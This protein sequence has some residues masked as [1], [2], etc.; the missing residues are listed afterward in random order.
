MG[1]PYFLNGVH[2]FLKYKDWGVQ[3]F[4]NIRTG[5]NKNGGVQIC[6]DSVRIW[7]ESLISWWGPYNH[8]EIGDPE[9]PILV[10]KILWHRFWRKYPQANANS[11][12]E[13]SKYCLSKYVAVFC[14]D[15]KLAS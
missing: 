7:M 3:I 12:L 5:G 14:L 8:D 4:Q 6:R 1:G 13:N 15:T 9:S 10:P 11:S 2:I